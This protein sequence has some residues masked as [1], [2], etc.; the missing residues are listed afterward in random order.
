MAVGR[1]EGASEVHK[2]VIGR[3]LARPAARSERNPC[4]RDGPLTDY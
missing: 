4:L 2:T 3:D 1:I